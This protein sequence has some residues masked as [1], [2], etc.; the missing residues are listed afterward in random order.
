MRL[1]D[2]AACAIA[3]SLL[4]T[5]C[6]RL[7]FIR[8]D[9][10]GGD[11]EKTS[12]TYSFEDD[13][14]T[15]RRVATRRQVGL[16]TNALRIGR[17]D[18]AEGH[19]RKALE[20]APDSADANTVMAIVQGKLGHAEAS[21]GYYARAAELA[22]GQGEVLNNYGVWLCGNGRAAESLAW[23][24]RALADAGYVRRD[25]A[26]AN[27]G[28]CAL[29]A[30]QTGRVERDLREALSLDPANATALA[31]M[32]RYQYGIGRYLDARAFSERRLDAAPATPDVLELA[33]QI[34]EKLGDK[35]AAAR[36]V[37]RLRTEFSQAGTVQP[38]DTSRP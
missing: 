27:A 14:A 22:P 1:R 12:P 17:L 35:A 8:P 38:G 9:M 11:Y 21:G 34:E 25:T 10:G 29:A 28:S 7:T 13:P 31:A 18:E 23:F 19:A 5:A 20:M 32:A 33:S 24:D 36:Y 4:A 15:K 30:G 6:S 26:L 3:L 16:A 2:A 37:R